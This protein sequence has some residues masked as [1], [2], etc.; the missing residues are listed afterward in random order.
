MTTTKDYMRKTAWFTSNGLPDPRLEGPQS[1]VTF[2]L[3]KY[4]VRFRKIIGSAN[5]IGKRKEFFNR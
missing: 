5:L 3:D 2:N 4:W 1:E